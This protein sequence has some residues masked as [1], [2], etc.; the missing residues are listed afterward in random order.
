[1]AGYRA[2][3][4]PVI[5]ATLADDFEKAAG[6]MH[7][8]R[9]SLEP[10]KDAPGD[11]VARSTG[12]QSSG[13]LRSMALADGLL[14]IPAAQTRLRAGERGAVQ[15]LDEGFFAARDPGF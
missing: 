1:M 6:R 7:F 4:R 9:V 10:K 2:W 11:F 5:H 12:S 14:I 3:F 8:V 13:V 15:V